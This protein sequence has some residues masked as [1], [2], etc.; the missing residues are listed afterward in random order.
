MEPTRARL[1]VV[2]RTVVSLMSLTL[3]LVF[4][5]LGRRW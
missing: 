4:E 1:S 3:A 2:V 5:E